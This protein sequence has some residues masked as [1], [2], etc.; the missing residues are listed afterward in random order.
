MGSFRHASLNLDIRPK[1]S[2]TQRI[3]TG[4]IGQLGRPTTNTQYLVTNTQTARLNY[5]PVG[6]RLHLLPRDR[7]C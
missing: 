3:I 7:E 6:L 4:H 1:P 2:V 5:Y